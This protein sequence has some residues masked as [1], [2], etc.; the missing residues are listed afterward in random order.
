MSD[1]DPAI[2]KDA[3]V[4]CLTRRGFFSE[5]NV[6]IQHQAYALAHAEDFYVDDHGANFRM[7]A[8]FA[9]PPSS[10]RELA[11]DRYRQ[12]VVCSPKTN[13]EEWTRRR[14]WVRKACEDH[15]VVRA[16]RAGF[17]GP[18]DQLVRMLARR[19]M[20][21][22]AELAEAVDAEAR[23]L[24]LDRTPFCAMH[25]RRGDKTEGYLRK[26]GVLGF[27]G[28]RA[29]VSAY[30]EE[31]RQIAPELST[32]LMLTDDHRP[33]A[34]AAAAYPDLGFVTLARPEAAGYFQDAFSG[35][36]FEEKARAAE[37]LVVEVLLA[38]RSQA[39]VGAFR[40][41]VSMMI[42]QIHPDPLACWSVDSVKTWRILM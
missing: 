35:L 38:A 15:A 1:L 26:S 22:R 42:A 3:V 40:S 17:E 31:M 16:P 41:N 25:I 11:A 8:L 4:Y 33:F 19:I 18:C 37:R 39:F 24:G 34:E 32:V 9:A 30:V 7:E 12:I 21:P 10:H 6:L 13:R 29:P 2:A 5:I 28:E 20:A 36:P 23:R 14:V 27:E